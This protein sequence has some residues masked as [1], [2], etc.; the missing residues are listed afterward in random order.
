MPNLSVFGEGLASGKAVFDVLDTL[1]RAR[2]HQMD[3]ALGSSILLDP[4]GKRFRSGAYPNLPE[5]MGRAISGLAIGPSTGSCGTAAFTQETV[6]VDD[7]ENDPLWENYRHLALPLGLRSCWSCPIIEAPNKVLGT[8][9]FYYRTTKKPSEA[10]LAVVQEASAIAR[11]AIQLSRARGTARLLTG[12]M[13]RLN[14]MVIITGADEGYGEGPR[15]IF[16]NESF[17]RITGFKRESVIGRR[18]AFLDARDGTSRRRPER[19]GAPLEPVRP[20][21]RNLSFERATARPTGSRRTSHPS[22]MTTENSHTLSRFSA[23]FPSASRQKKRFATAS[24]RLTPYSATF[25]GW[26]IAARTIRTGPSIM[27]ARAARS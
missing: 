22:S 8:F 15:V 25:P 20:P 14:D 11:I 23:I 26:R 24:A 17:E 1:V 2:E 10:E 21:V 5:S 4:D 16:V 6:I 3:G 13:S 19:S 7:I 9:A 18:P 12:A 27:R